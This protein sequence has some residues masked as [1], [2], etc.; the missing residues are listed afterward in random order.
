M[1]IHIK[2]DDNFKNQNNLIFKYL[3]I[4][5]FMTSYVNIEQYRN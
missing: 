1:H 3:N 2:V 4:L 5:N